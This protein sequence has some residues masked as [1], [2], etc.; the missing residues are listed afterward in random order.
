MTDTKTQRVGVWERRRRAR[1]SERERERERRVKRKGR[2]TKNRRGEDG[3]F[4]RMG[5]TFFFSFPTFLVC[6]AAAPSRLLPCAAARSR[7]L[8]VRLDRRSHDRNEER[9]TRNEHRRW[10]SWTR[11]GTGTVAAEV[12][13]SVETARQQCEARASSQQTPVVRFV[14]PPAI[15][16]G[17]SG[18]GEIDQPRRS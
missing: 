4:I 2:E 3:L 13:A 10:R 11:A 9:W 5:I 7:L 6:P 12:E 17:G 1:E 8:S 14:F 15:H 16:R 18:S